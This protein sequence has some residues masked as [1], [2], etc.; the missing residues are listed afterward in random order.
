MHQLRQLISPVPRIRPSISGKELRAVCSAREELERS[1]LE[2]LRSI[3]GVEYGLLLPYGRS[4]ISLFCRTFL[5]QS[6]PEVFIPAYNCVVVANAVA[7]NGMMPRFVDIGLR[8]GNIDPEALALAV[9]GHNSELLVI[10]HMYGNSCGLDE[11]I[12]I[13]RRANIR[14]LMC[15]AALALYSYHNGKHVCEFGDVALLSFSTGKHLTAIEGGALLTNDRQIFVEL[16]REFE[17]VTKSPTVVTELS[18]IAFLLGIAATYG[19]NLYAIADYLYHQTSALDFL[20]GELKG[21]EVELPRDVYQGISSIQKRVLAAQ[22]EREA[23]IFSRR[24]LIQKRY[25]EAGFHNAIINDSVATNQL[26]HFSIRSVDRNGLIQAGMRRGI[27]LDGPLFDYA[28]SDLS[29][30]REFGGAGCA[31][32]TSL[33]ASCVNLPSYPDLTHEQQNRVIQ[34]VHDC[35]RPRK[36]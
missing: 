34:L 16:E 35:E 28:I 11:I 6:K 21:E 17:S 14:F 9:K 5:T 10:T 7:A 18:K 8:D 22:L 3:T 29:Q 20:T 13:Q 26:S 2:R 19:L 31:N 30:F 25:L 12:S 32:A 1:I 4:A 36:S 27:F 24:S 23:E 15:D 33:A